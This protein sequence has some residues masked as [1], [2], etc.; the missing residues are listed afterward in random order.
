MLAWTSPPLTQGQDW[1]EE[2]SDNL[3]RPK[4]R[5]QG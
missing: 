1:E 2:Y 5:T 4:S 3:A